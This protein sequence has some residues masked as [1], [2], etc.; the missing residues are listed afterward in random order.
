MVEMTEI[1]KLPIDGFLIVIVYFKEY[2]DNTANDTRRSLKSMVKYVRKKQ[3]VD[4]GDHLFALM[5]SLDLKYLYSLL[6]LSDKLEKDDKSYLA[7]HHIS[8]VIKNP[9]GGKKGS[10]AIGAIEMIRY[11]CDNTE[12]VRV[13]YEEIKRWCEKRGWDYELMFADWIIERR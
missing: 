11:R 7:G 8:A 3:D 10:R 1:N 4:A 6:A 2:K 5:K 9:P 12:Q 13:L